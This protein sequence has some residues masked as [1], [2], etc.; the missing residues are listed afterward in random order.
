[1]A[2]VKAVMFTELVGTFGGYQAT[3]LKPGMDIAKAFKNYLMMGMNAGGFPT[4]SVV[5]AP[6]G[7]GIGSVFASQMLV[8]AAIG[9]QIGSHLSTMALT[10]MSGQQIGPPVA[11]PTHTPQLMKLFSAHAPSGINF[12]NELASILDTWAKTWVVSGL[13]PGSPP[14][15]FSGPLS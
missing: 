13:I 7:A 9:S 12:A 8:G 10:Y 3:P 5:D 11:P 6:A 15:P 14:V 2:L 1:M 4:A